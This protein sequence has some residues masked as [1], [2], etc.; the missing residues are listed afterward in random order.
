MWVIAAKIALKRFR[1]NYFNALTQDN[2]VAF[3][4]G[5][6]VAVV[7]TPIIGL[8]LPR[9]G[10]FF[11]SIIAV[12]IGSSAGGILA[13][14]I[15]KSV[16][17]R[18]GRNLRYFAM[19]GVVLGVL[20]GSVIVLLIAG[21]FP[22]LTI[23]MIVFHCAGTGYSPPDVA[24]LASPGAPRWISD[25][26]QTTLSCFLIG[27]RALWSVCSAPWAMLSFLQHSSFNHTGESTPCASVPPS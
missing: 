6:L 9:F 20:I 7:A 26:G 18:R 8:I 15:R 27:T 25:S 23:P 4:V 5:F 19:A 1:T 17:K 21:Y 3:I 16:G 22:L 2:P 24:I 12:M 13:Q 11:G 14:I 10:L